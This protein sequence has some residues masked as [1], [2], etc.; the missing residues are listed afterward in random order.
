[1]VHSVCSS[2]HRLSIAPTGTLQE[3]SQ[4]PVP[5]PYIPSRS[6]NNLASVWNNSS[7]HEAYTPLWKTS[8]TPTPITCPRLLLL[9]PIKGKSLV[10]CPT[11]LH[12]T[13][14]KPQLGLPWLLA[15]LQRHWTTSWDLPLFS[16]H[17]A[18]VGAFMEPPF[19]LFLFITHFV[20]HNRLPTYSGNYRYR[21]PYNFESPSRDTG[22]HD[23]SRNHFLTFALA[24]IFTHSG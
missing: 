6:T 8:S 11:R 18:M 4:A 23:P 19:W 22:L 7:A 14:T 13:Y 9:T 3:T 2:Q 20:S 21:D 12:S 16:R 17:W 5:L 24:S 15:E 10:L 1:M